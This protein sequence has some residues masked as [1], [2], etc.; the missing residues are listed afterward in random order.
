[1]VKL[2]LSPLTS[3]VFLEQYVNS[4]TTAGG[5]LRSSS[6]SGA[7]HCPSW[8]SGVLVTSLPPRPSGADYRCGEG[9]G[10]RVALGLLAWAPQLSPGQLEVMAQD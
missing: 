2:L 1:M 8:V 10:K 9:P 4:W 5:C 6:T 7:P 3:L